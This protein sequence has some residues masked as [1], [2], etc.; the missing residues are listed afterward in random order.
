MYK[1]FFFPLVTVS[2][3]M[4]VEFGFDNDRCYKDKIGMLN[5]ILDARYQFHVLILKFV[6]N[7]TLSCNIRYSFSYYIKKKICMASDSVY[8]L[9]QFSVF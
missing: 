6:S 1:G 7:K 2:T 5:E 3:I 9:L 8:K 4:T